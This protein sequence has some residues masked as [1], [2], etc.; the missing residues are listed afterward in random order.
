LAAQA[1]LGADLPGHAG[2]HGGEAAELIDHGVDRVLQL[3]DLALHVYGDPL[4]DVAAASG[5]GDVGDV[6]HLPGE[7]P[8]HR[9]HA[10]GEVLPG[11]GHAPDVR[12]AA[13]LAFGPHLAGHAGD[14]RGE[15]GELVH[16]RVDGRLQLQDLALHVYGDLLGEVAAG[17]RLGDLGDVAHLAREVAGHEVHAVGQV[18]PGAGDTLHLGL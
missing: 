2:D 12:L 10:V 14:L 1:S 17:H 4:G 5:G 15:A 11:P 8:R 18:L 7:V 13:E 16:H 3:E 9:V 6:A